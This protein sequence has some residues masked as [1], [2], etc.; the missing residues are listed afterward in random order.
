[1]PVY[2]YS[3]AVRTVRNGWTVQQGVRHFRQAGG[4]VGTTNWNAM[5]A[6]ARATF[7][8]RANE[9]NAH[10]G[11]IPTGNETFAL[12][13]HK[14]NLYLQ[15][16]EVAVRNRVTGGID[17]IPFTH[18]TTELRSRKYVS[19]L[20]MGTIEAGAEPG[21]SFAGTQILGAAYT[22]T[23]DLVPIGSVSGRAA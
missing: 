21:G 3:W 5:V 4:H 8:G 2:P 20:A 9:L 11:R 18:Q 12:E 17:Y 16:V 7:A 22:G 10:R 19:D 14:A 13:S 6:N 15:Q 23:Y 1:M